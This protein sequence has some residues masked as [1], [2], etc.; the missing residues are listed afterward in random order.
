MGANT[1]AVIL[2]LVGIVEV[3]LGIVLGF[4]IRAQTRAEARIDKLSD[5]FAQFKA[6]VPIKYANDADIARVETA[7][8]GVRQDLNTFTTEIRTTLTTLSATLNQ[9]VGANTHRG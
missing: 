3:L 6:E 8:A 9:L 7:I 5:D 1:L 4:I 2:C